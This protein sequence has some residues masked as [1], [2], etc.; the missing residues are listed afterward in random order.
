MK[1]IL[2]GIALS[3]VILQACNNDDDNNED[4]V[5]L[6]IEEQN[7]YDDA[8][9]IDF[10]NKNY[11]NS[12]GVITEF[13]D[14]VTTDDNEIKLIDYDYVKLPSGVIYLLR[15]GA[16]PE[17]GKEIG[18]TDVIHL[19]IVAKSYIST[20]VDDK[21]VYSNE[22]TFSN[23]L[24]SGNVVKDPAYYYV[25]SSVLKNYNDTYHTTYGRNFYEIEGL[26]EGLKF[27]KSFDL[28]DSADYNMQ[29]V[30]IVPS[31]A[32]FARD[33]NIYAYTDRSIVFNFQVYKTRARDMA[34]E[35]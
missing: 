9:A 23:S 19:M 10:M 31:R 35:D 21:I 17:P 3:A 7:S 32:A 29:G 5:I 33:S 24:A 27:F 25:K 14:T 15:P 34:T 13:D 11:L 16:Q 4:A 26:Q 28:E 6:T 18:S 20:K 1:K 8:A 2:L 22:S 12:K 30:I